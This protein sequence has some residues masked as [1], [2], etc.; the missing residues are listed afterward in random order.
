MRLI[1]MSHLL[2]KIIPSDAEPQF[3]LSYILQEAH[4]VIARYGNNQIGTQLPEWIIDEPGRSIAFSGDNAV[5]K[6]IVELEY[7]QHLLDGQVLDAGFI[8]VDQGSCQR[9]MFMKNQKIT[10]NTLKGVQR[11]IR[12]I[13]RRQIERGE[14][15]HAREYRPRT[16]QQQEVPNT[17]FH[18]FYPDSKSTEQN[19][20]LCI[21]MLPVTEGDELRGNETFDHYGFSTLSEHRGS[22]PLISSIF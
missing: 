22:V 14:I 4:P 18:L 16:D 1:I 20:P 12:R 15:Q 19:M 13:I 5:L 21:Q 6:K 11:K 17:F 8:D 2:F 9:A 3:L 10:S 7:F